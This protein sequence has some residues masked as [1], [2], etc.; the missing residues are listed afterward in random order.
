MEAVGE[1]LYFETWRRVQV[2]VETGESGDTLLFNRAKLGLCDRAHNKGSLHG[3]HSPARCPERHITCIAY[4]EDCVY[5]SILPS[6]TLSNY[7]GR[8]L[9][10]PGGSHLCEPHGVK[11]PSKGCVRERNAWIHPHP[12]GL[13]AF[14][15]GYPPPPHQK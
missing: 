14:L 9:L 13:H 5:S 2:P 15:I 6:Y 10:K 11:R 4:T 12:T 3:F 8:I 1:G 7:K